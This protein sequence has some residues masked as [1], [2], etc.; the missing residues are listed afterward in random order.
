MA[1]RFTF[2]ALLVVLV[3]CVSIAQTQESTGPLVPGRQRVLIRS[4]RDGSLQPS[5][6]IVPEGH[7]ANVPTPVLGEFAF[8]RQL[9]SGISRDNVIANDDISKAR[10]WIRDSR[11]VFVRPMPSAFDV[12]CS[13]L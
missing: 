9:A 11:S 5:Y 8:M 6:I 4:S 1:F 12:R 7:N 3:S 10:L 13:S 2:C